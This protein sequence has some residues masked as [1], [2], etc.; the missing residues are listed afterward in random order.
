MICLLLPKLLM[1]RFVIDDKVLSIANMCGMVGLIIGIIFYGWLADKISAARTL[2]IG[3]AVLTFLALTLYSYLSHGNA[4]QIIIVYSLL[5]LGSGVLAMCPLIFIQ[6][7]ATPKRLTI[8][9]VVFNI[10]T[11]LTGAIVPFGLYYATDIIAFT[12]ALFI[13][14]VCSCAFAIGTLINASPDLNKLEP[15]PSN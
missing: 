8:T 7:Y 4:A 11:V 12:P 3:S 15:M 6:L 9:G 13:T 1:I 10:V 5:G 2:M 14:F